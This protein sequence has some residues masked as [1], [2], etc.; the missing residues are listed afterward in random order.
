MNKKRVKHF[1]PNKDERGAGVPACHCFQ[2]GKGYFL[3]AFL[4]GFNEVAI[5]RRGVTCGN[6][7]RTHEFLGS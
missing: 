6:C 2:D 4:I 7:R 5:T 3:M 1:V